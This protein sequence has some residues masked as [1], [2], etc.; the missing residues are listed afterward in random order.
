MK[1]ANR[2]EEKRKIS[3]LTS[4]DQLKVKEEIKD[5]HKLG[6]VILL[7]WFLETFSIMQIILKSKF[8]QAFT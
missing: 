8:Y 7:W 1:T 5:D 4:H 3:I 6:T 2:K